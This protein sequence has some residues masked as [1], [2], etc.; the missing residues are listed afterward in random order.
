M[1]G[2]VVMLP[3]SVRRQNFLLY[4]KH[5]RCVSVMSATIWLYTREVV[6]EPASKI[7]LESNI[8]IVGKFL[9]DNRFTLR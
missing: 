8:H 7:F 4:A 1:V 6:K 2:L 3:C 5:G 9:K